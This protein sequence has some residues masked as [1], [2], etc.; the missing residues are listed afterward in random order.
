M[1]TTDTEGSGECGCKELVGLGTTLSFFEDREALGVLWMLSCALVHVSVLVLQPASQVKMLSLRE[2]K[3]FV[4][5][6]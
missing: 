3:P 4:Q 2:I 5:G 1:C 6:P